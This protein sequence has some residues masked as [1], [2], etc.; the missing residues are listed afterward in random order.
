[1]TSRRLKDLLS[2]VRQGDATRDA[3]VRQSDLSHVA[4]PRGRDTRQVPDQALSPSR[5]RKVLAMLARDGVRYAVL[6]QDHNTDPVIMTV[7]TPDGTRE[8]FIPRDDYDPFAIVE[9]V[10]R[11]DTGRAGT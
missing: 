10:H 9:K 1:M 3:T 7:A 4:H 6:V 11:W 2:R 5:R 8:V